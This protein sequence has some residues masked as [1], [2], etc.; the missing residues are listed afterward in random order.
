MTSSEITQ[1]LTPN[2]LKWATTLLLVYFGARLLFFALTVSASVPPD[3]VTHAGLCKVFSKVLLLPDNGPETYEFGLVTNIPWLYYWLMGKL[4]HLNF[5]GIPDL[6]F[7]RLLNIPFAFGTVFFVRRT[8]LLL[9]DD[10]LAQLLV[11]VVM[12]NTAMF[13]LMSASVSYDNMTNLLAAMAVFYS[14]AFFKQRSGHLL[15]AAILVQL[16]GCLTKITFL[17]LVLVLNLLLVIH[18]LKN[19]RHVPAE[20][21]RCLRTSGRRS[22]LFGLAIL[23]ALGL[24]LNLYAGNYLRYGTLTPSMSAVLSPEI[25]MNY[26]LDAR[27]IIFDR[28]RNGKISYMEAL[29]LTGEIKHPGDKADTFY[30]LMNYENMEATIFGIKAHLIMVKDA[31][32]LVPIYAVMSL[33]LLGFLIRWRPR[34]SGW[35]PP[36]LAAI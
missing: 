23:I 12:T 26:R 7:L 5:F 22:W 25:A 4:L 2:F 27:G 33:A 18:E 17:P 21:K 8:L 16:A 15:A 14:L 19:L 35:L 3:E 20:L 29:I 30:L 9:T 32:Y 31:R 6:V 1:K 34:D 10:R 11:V 13:S 36:C 28:Y 24:N